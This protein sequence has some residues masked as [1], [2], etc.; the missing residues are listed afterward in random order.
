MKAVIL[1]QR[2]MKV[3]IAEGETK[4]KRNDC[5][6]VLDDALQQVCLLNYFGGSD[7]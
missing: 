6:T 3:L 7:V 5:S 2:R 1:A 4:V